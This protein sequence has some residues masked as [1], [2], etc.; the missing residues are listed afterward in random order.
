MQPKIHELDNDHRIAFEP[1]HHE[2]YHMNDHVFELR[3]INFAAS[4]LPAKLRY[5]QL[6]S[7]KGPP[8]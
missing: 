3:H 1:N 2:P 5:R 8:T 4:L 7:R 6:F